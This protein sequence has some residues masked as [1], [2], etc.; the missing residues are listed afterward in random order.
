[1]F[2][3]GLPHNLELST[4]KHYFERFGPVEEAIILEDKRTHKPRGFGFITYKH[5]RSVDKVIELKN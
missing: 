4:F 5:L 2:V 3:G 1:V